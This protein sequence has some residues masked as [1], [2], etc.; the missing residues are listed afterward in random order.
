ME[1]GA[2]P[3]GQGAGNTPFDPQALAALY[4]RMFQQIGGPGGMGMGGMGGMGMNQM[5]MNGMMGMGMGGGGSGS[6]ERLI[7]VRIVQKGSEGEERRDFWW[8]GEEERN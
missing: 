3:A 5:M 7:E 4:T 1:A 2:Q 6:H 8:V